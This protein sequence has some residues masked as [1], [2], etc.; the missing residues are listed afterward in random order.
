MGGQA[1]TKKKSKAKRKDTKTNGGMSV[2]LVS[3]MLNY[4]ALLLNEK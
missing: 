2:L 4:L 1:K 3:V